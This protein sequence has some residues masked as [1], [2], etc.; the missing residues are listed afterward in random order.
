MKDLVKE[1][2]DSHREMVKRSL[3]SSGNNYRMKKAFEKSRR[4]EEVTI[5]FLGA[6]ITM[7]RSMTDDKGFATLSTRYYTS[8]FSNPD[9]V[10]YINAGMNG[11]TSTLGLIRADRD[12]LD[13]RPDIVFVE[14]AVNDSK[15]N[16]NREIYESLV[17]RLLNSETKPAVV[18][19][20]MSSDMGY[21]CQGHMQVIGEYYLLP[22]ISACDAVLQEVAAGRMS[23]SSYADDNIHPN[24]SGNQLVTEFINYFYDTIDEAEPDEEAVLPK[25]P[26][27]GAAYANMKLLDAE[28]A[29]VVTYGSFQRMQLLEEFKNGWLHDKTSGNKG[30]K[31]KL[32]CKSLFAI[33]REK[34]DRNE[35]DAQIYV[36]GQLK[37]SMSG[38]R[39]FG[40]GNPM[41]VFVFREEESK[42][43]IL[44]I[45]MSPGD[46]QK[47]FA[48]LAFGYCS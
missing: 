22:M 30:M 2:S 1:R 27:F 42:E 35:G 6:S 12:V 7:L 16:L 25:H 11:T 3:I 44:E 43:H 24:E 33:Y 15:D 4:G 36:D 10:R 34:N 13:Y 40:W 8:K 18:L 31:I 26:F 37:A 32:K 47:E 29:D 9:N 20:F 23:W 19:L 14:F 46:E 38:Y 48:F 21:T 39:I 41:S 17:L 28:N 45:R 5:V